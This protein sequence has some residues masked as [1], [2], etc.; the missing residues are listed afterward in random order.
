MACSQLFKAGPL[1]SSHIC[2]NRGE[3][4]CPRSQGWGAA[5]LGPECWA[6]R[7]PGPGLRPLRVLTVPSFPLS[8]AQLRLLGP[9][10]PSKAGSQPCHLLRS[11]WLSFERGQSSGCE[12]AEQGAGEAWGR[13]FLTVSLR[14]ATTPLCTLPIW[15]T[16]R[17]SLR[18][19]MQAQ[20]EEKGIG[21]S[22]C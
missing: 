18:P 19:L 4:S 17:G 1:T 12:E 15:V 8:Q 10:L 14:A 5:G 6:W 7:T 16:Q 20:A 2:R 3:A 13:P 11:R 9:L 22:P 21:S